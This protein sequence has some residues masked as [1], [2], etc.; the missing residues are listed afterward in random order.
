MSKVSLVLYPGENWEDSSVTFTGETVSEVLAMKAEYLFQTVGAGED[1]SL[2]SK[3]S[4]PLEEP[5][6]L[7]TPKPSGFLKKLKGGTDG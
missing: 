7:T 2:A 6:A 1:P 5:L 3:A 4:K